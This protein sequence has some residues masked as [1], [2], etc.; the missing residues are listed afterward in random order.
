MFRQ[1]HW[2]SFIFLHTSVVWPVFES[3]RVLTARQLQVTVFAFSCE[4][5]TQCSMVSAFEGGIWL[6]VD[7]GKTG[8]LA[9]QP[10]RATHKARAKTRFTL[11]ISVTGTSVFDRE[12]TTKTLSKRYSDLYKSLL[13]HRNARA[14]LSGV[15]AT[16]RRNS[17]ILASPTSIDPRARSVSYL[18]A[19]FRNQT[20]SCEPDR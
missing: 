12:G 6:R 2:S 3:M 16:R 17:P 18:S 13:N 4:M 7:A 10:L 20:G 11:L 8:F 1:R 5:I 9:A 14:T 15:T 19:T